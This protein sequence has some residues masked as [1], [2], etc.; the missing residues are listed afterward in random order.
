MFC[1]ALDR[2]FFLI[3]PNSISHLSCD[4]KHEGMLMIFFFFLL[5][6]SDSGAH[7]LLNSIPLNQRSRWRQS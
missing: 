2:I 1:K 4:Y 7:A 5:E 3:I 6:Q